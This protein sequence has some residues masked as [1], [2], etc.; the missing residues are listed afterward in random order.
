MTTFSCRGWCR[1]GWAPGWSCSSSSPS[2]CPMPWRSD[3]PGVVISSKECIFTQRLTAHSREEQEELDWALDQLPHHRTKRFPFL[4]RKTRTSVVIKTLVQCLGVIGQ[5]SFPP[6]TT[7]S[8]IDF[9]VSFL[10]RGEAACDASRVPACPHTHPR[11]AFPQ[12]E[13]F[14]NSLQE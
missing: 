7:V 3:F 1:R 12:V 5:R 10:D 9:Q 11:P 2:S 6:Q 4:W 13:R 14:A 8:E